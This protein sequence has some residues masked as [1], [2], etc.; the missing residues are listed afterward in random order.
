MISGPSSQLI[1]I[2]ASLNHPDVAM[3]S[4]SSI[5]DHDGKRPVWLWTA[6]NGFYA[7]NPLWTVR[8][9]GAGCVDLH[10]LKQPPELVHAGGADFS[11][12]I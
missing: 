5:A 7:Q 2:G 9:P 3:V 1:V 12:F 10:G 6:N 11:S 4:N 8:T